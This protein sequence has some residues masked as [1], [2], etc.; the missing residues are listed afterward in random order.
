MAKYLLDTN[1]CIFF[2]KGKY[3][4]DKKIMQ[5][6]VENCYISEITAAELLYGA[7]HSKKERHIS[8]TK[9]FINEFAI[10]PIT[11]II[12]DFARQKDSLVTSG[13]IID[14]FDIFIGMSAVKNNFVM[15]TD[16][17]KHLSR[18]SGIKIENWIERK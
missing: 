5:V 12:D 10:I 15:V 18:I 4:L 3:E 13:Q 8:E 2:M 7:Y 16:N 11:S 17:V 14:D 6:G 1:I 9:Q